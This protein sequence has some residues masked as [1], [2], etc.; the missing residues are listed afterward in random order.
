MSQAKEE[1]VDRPESS[2]FDA[3]PRLIR[4]A[5]FVALGLGLAGSCYLIWARGE[6]MIVDLAT[7]GGKVFCF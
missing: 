1:A 6:A 5:G 4:R 3:A 7:I 2:V